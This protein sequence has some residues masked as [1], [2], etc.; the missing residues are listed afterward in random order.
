MLDS[1]ETLSNETV[2]RVMKD[3]QNFFQANMGKHP[4]L[5][6]LFPIDDRYMVG[7]RR[8]HKYNAAPPFLTLSHPTVW[9]AG[10]T[11]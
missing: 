1:M 2:D 8:L 10:S 9:L 11:F 7:D 4:E 5:R 6:H 3:T